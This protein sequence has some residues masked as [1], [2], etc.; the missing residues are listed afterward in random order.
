MLS[1][2]SEVALLGSDS[3]LAEAASYVDTLPV[4]AAEHS[5]RALGMSVEIAVASIAESAGHCA[6]DVLFD[7]FTQCLADYRSGLAVDH[8]SKLAWTA[9]STL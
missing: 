3:G 8:G 5:R 2:D 1:F 7:L 6:D 4:T 9:D